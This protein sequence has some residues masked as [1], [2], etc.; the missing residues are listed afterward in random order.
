MFSISVNS[1]FPAFKLVR[2]A[3][4]SSPSRVVILLLFIVT[5]DTF[6]RLLITNSSITHRS[7]W[8]EELVD[9]KFSRITLLNPGVLE[10]AISSATG[11]LL[12]LAAI[13][14]GRFF[15]ITS[16]NSEL[17]PVSHLMVRNLDWS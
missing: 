10:K 8:T 1:L 11:L 2:A 15:S 3:K 6:G 14:V 7:S 13:K 9:G 5:I 12:L 4:S 17:L 16:V